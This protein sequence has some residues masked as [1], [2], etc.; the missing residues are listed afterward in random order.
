VLATVSHRFDYDENI[1]DYSVENLVVVVDNPQTNDPQNRYQVS[2]YQIHSE[3]DN[4]TRANDVML[5]QLNRSITFGADVSKICIDP[6]TLFLGL[7]CFV[8]EWVSIENSSAYRL[9]FGLCFCF[10]CGK[11]YYIFM[12]LI[13]ITPKQHSHQK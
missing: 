11:L 5:L 2:R 8:T 7:S 6:V 12:Y 3:F 9:F 10:N 13:I 1:K 4:N